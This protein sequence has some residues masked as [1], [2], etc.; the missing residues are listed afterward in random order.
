M[1]K[2]YLA[3]LWHHHQPIYKNPSTGVYELPWVRL[4]AVKDYYD[5]A[6][7]LDEFP[8]IKCNFNLVPSLLVQLDEYAKGAARDKFLE[9]TL[10][11]AASLSEFEK[12]FILHNFFMANWKTM[13]FPNQR[14]IYLLEKRG[15]HTSLSELRS[16]Q[17]AFSVKDMRDLQVWFNLSWMDPYWRRNDPLVK[18]LYEKGA[19]FTE[20]EKADLIKKQLEI[21][22]LVATRYRRMQE[23]GQIEVSVTPFYHPILPLLCDTGNALGSSPGIKLP[24]PRFRHREDA[25]T[26]VNKAVEYYTNVFGSAPRGMWPAEGSVSDDTIPLFAEAGIKWIA[27]DEGVLLGSSPA[28]AASRANLYRGYAVEVFGSKIN[29]VFRDHNISDAIGFT[30][31]EWDS[32]SAVDDFMSNIR[33]IADSL[34]DSEEPYIISVILDGENCWEHYSN[35]GWDFLSLLYGE[36]SREPQIET[37]RLC[38]FFEKHPPKNTLQKLWPGS[39]INANYEIWIGDDEDNLAW[40]YLERTRKYL[41]EYFTVHPD[42]TGSPDALKAWELMY[43]AEGSDWNWWYGK[44]HSSGN[45][46]TFDMLFRQHLICIYETLK[47]EVPLYLYN[48]IKGA[49]KKKP[50][51]ELK[52]LIS[53]KIDGLVTDY[54]EWQ[55]AGCYDVGCAGGSMHQARTLLKSFHYGFDLTN[56]YWRIDLN[57]PPDHHI[58]DEISF[59]VLFLAPKNHKISFRLDAKQDV[60]DAVLNSPASSFELKNEHIL[61]KNIIE[62]SIPISKLSLPDDAKS[63]EFVIIA[64]KY[65]REIERWPYQS[66]VAFDIPN[67]EFRLKNWSAI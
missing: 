18:S 55:S 60:I 8:N 42:K 58:I 34:P 40:T 36:L 30:Y 52:D 62:I 14:Y 25:K 23:K 12:V 27:S 21:C 64:K 33:S 29:M 3:F 16:V 61:F 35:D 65:N 46:E 26:Q 28:L 15:R 24:E 4:H 56:L 54:F 39:W 44:D 45:D 49:F 6:A 9:L 43:T 66:S 20:N 38:D 11:N 63:I 2:V 50:S 51:L 31:N 22:G 7:V 47:E 59:E 19:N 48:P 13:V 5:T 67:E 41:S 1:K 57:L 53:P 17:S 32:K 10:K 37:T